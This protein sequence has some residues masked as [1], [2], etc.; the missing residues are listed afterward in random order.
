MLK[1]AAACCMNLIRCNQ[2][3]RWMGVL[4]DAHCLVAILDRLFFSADILSCRSRKSTGVT[5]NISN[6]SVLFKCPSE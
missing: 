3:W 5:N 6:G 1:N 4:F 2:V